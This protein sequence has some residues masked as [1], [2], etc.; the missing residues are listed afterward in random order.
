M[1]PLTLIFLLAVL[2]GTATRLWLA[3]RQIAAVTRHRDQ[4][5]E[6]FAQTVTA[7]DHSK[8]A[9]YAVARTRLARIDT[10][11]D[12]VVLLA[13]TLGGGIEA[14]DQLCALVVRAEPWHGALVMLA[15][16][17]VVALIGLPLSLWSTF[18]VEARFGFN[19]TSVAL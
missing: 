12:A 8:A 14:I 17:L 18:R 11:I 6:P 3:N 1:Q 5:P 15:V 13:L 16:L 19:R 7:A 9:D 4:V 10:V 2:A